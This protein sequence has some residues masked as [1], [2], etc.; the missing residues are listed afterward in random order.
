MA[1]VLPAINIKAQSSHHALFLM[2]LAGTF[3]LFTLVFSQDYWPRFNLVLIFIYLSTLVTFITGLAKYLQPQYSLC[4]D[5]KGIKYQHSY[6]HW[7][8]NWQQ[9]ERI[10]LI[11]ETIGLTQIQLPYI[12]IRLTHLTDLAKQISPRLANRLIHEQKPLL[13][14]AIKLNL[15]SMEQSQL[16]FSPYLLASGEIL[17][18]PLAA[19]LHHSS[20]LH[21]AFG[22]HVFLPETAIDRDLDKFCQLLQQC[23]KSSV[24][25]S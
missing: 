11:N 24:T 15:L 5:P 7:Q 10:S 1:K 25:Y 4:L 2:I 3:A 20:A 13:A 19:F 23:K 17:K 9:I 8:I 12:G 18:G 21:L 6:G 14:L 22:Y 16:N